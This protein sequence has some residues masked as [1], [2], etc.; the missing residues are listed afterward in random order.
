VELAGKETN[1]VDCS[2]FHHGFDIVPALLF[3]AIDHC[4][5]QFRYDAT[6]LIHS[7]TIVQNCVFCSHVLT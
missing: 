1:Y 2:K 5:T 6:N 3:L 7:F 4:L